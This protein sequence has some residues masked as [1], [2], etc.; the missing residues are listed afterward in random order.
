[1]HAL[2]AL[3]IAYHIW[4]GFVCHAQMCRID[5]TVASYSAIDLRYKDMYLVSGSIASIRL[6]YS[7][8]DLISYNKENN[9]NQVAFQL[10]MIFQTK[11]DLIK[12]FRIPYRVKGFLCWSQVALKKLKGEP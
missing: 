4:H 10:N 7:L 1:M 12:L 11:R 3:F 6:K 9:Q 8:F 5:H 2:I